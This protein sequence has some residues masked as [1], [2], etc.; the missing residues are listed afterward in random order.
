MNDCLET[1]VKMWLTLRVA[2]TAQEVNS[3]QPGMWEHAGVLII[4]GAHRPDLDVEYSLVLPRRYLIIISLARSFSD[5]LF[6]LCSSPKR[7]GFQI[8]R[9]GKRN[10]PQ[11]GVACD[12]HA[13][14]HPGNAAAV[15]K[16]LLGTVWSLQGSALA[17]LRRARR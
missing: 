3:S 12:A 8:R 9:S 1:A 16:L 17:Q 15:M 11:T 6:C 2:G 10:P 4:N 5:L 13:V 7:L 14:C